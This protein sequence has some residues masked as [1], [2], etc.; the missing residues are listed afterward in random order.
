MD[1]T[2]LSH[3]DDQIDLLIQVDIAEKLDDGTYHLIAPNGNLAGKLGIGE[4]HAEFHSARETS[5]DHLSIHIP[6]EKA[7]N[8][9]EE[10]EV[11]EQ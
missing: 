1:T 11:V 9:V 10:A 7:E 4:E 5:G 3:K 2:N 6:K 8:F